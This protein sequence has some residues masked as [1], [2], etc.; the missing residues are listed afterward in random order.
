[1]VAAATAAELPVPCVVV[2]SAD[3]PAFVDESSLVFAVSWSGETPT[4][5]VACARALERGAALVAISGPGRLGDLAEEAGAVT[6]PVPTGPPQ[7]RAALGALS[8]PML[9]F[10]ERLGLVSEMA[11]RL[12]AAVDQL[13]RRRDGLLGDASP[14][15]DDVAAVVARRIGRTIPLVHGSDGL[16]GVAAKSPAFWSVLP[17]LGHNEV[18]G[19]GQ[20]GDVTRQLIT[21]VQLR[22]TSED[23]AT[24]RR[25]DLEAELRREI[26]A[27]IVPVVA[28]GRGSIAQFFDLALVGDVVSLHLAASEDVDPGPVPAVTDMEEIVRHAG[29]PPNSVA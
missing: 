26:A 1:V 21:L 16:I 6:V 17:E 5:L 15:R 25:F 14:H 12:D 22:S 18:A 10:L 28:Q 27:D 24:A 20:S 11:P 8:V 13:K 7:A 4:T 3:V 29:D 23:A 9:V 19:W 2:K